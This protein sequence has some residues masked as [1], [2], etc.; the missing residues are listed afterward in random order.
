M[1][2]VLALIPAR[3]QSKGIPRKN[4][5]NMA[6]KPLI[7]WTIEA[8]LQCSEISAVVV[9]TEDEEIAEVARAAG[10]QTPFMRP[11]ELA[12]DEAPGIAPVLHAMRELP[13]Y[14]AVLVLQPTSPLRGADDIR[15]IVRQANETRAPSVVSVCEVDSHPAWMFAR[16][17][18]GALTP[19]LDSE[20]PARRQ[21]MQ[22]LFTLNGAMY[23]ATRDW[24]EA[25]E[26]LIG[27]STLGYVMSTE[28]SVDIDTP[29]DWRLAEFLFAE[30]ERIG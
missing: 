6:G 5:R 25:R 15:A 18:T 20:P 12:T 22:K 21:D 7:A 23:Y 16:Q 13:Q 2:D 30:R 8:A 24:L 14:G 10:A 26:S 11:M 19:F 29:Y 3:G 9:S 17:D 27:D 1:S 28:N 4:I